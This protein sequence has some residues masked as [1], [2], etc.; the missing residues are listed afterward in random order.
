MYSSIYF[1]ISIIYLLIK[2]V[3]NFNISSLVINILII[4]LW[5]YIL[6]FLCGMGFAIIA[7][8]IL[9][10]ILIFPYF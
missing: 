2:S 4:M 1:V 8:L 9:M 10:L 6:N 7:W 5:S 3:T